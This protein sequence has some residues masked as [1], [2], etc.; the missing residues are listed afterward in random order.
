MMGKRIGVAVCAGVFATAGALSAQ[1]GSSEEN[2]VRWLSNEQETA[3][4]LSAAPWAVSGHA[5]VYVIGEWGYEIAQEGDNGFTCYVDRG[6]NGQDILPKCTDWSG[7]QSHFA[8]LQIR[9]QQRSQGKTVAEIQTA[10]A[11]GMMDGSIQTARAGSMTYM[12]STEAVRTG[13]NGEEWAVGPRILVHAPFAQHQS[14]GM[15]EATGKKASWSGVPFIDWAGG[16]LTSI[17]IPVM[18]SAEESDDA[19]SPDTGALNR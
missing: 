19:T 2:A 17:V 12:M 8:V 15:D 7:S 14:L 11:A 5:S 4:A 18:P 10:I 6:W 1:E 13:E 3:L 9:E 16:P